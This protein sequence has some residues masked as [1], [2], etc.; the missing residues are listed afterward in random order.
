M[1]K[2]GFTLIELLSS[3][4]LMTIIA[5]IASINLIKILDE[6][7]KIS[8]KNTESIITTAACLYIELDKNADLKE[9]CLTN[10]CTITTDILI[11]EGLLNSEDVNKTEV[12]NI[13]KENN[14]KIC[15]IK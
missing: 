14:T 1:N 12:I 10:G 15:K 2:K 13:S 8:T 5:T 4:T 3:I 6:K 11:K 9:E 7:E